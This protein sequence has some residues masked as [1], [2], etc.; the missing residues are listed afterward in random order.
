[1]LKVETPKN[2]RAPGTGEPQGLRAWGRKGG[3][4]HI[5][6]LTFSELKFKHNLVHQLSVHISG[7]FFPPISLVYSFICLFI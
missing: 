1:M 3:S 7:C 6:I 5:A 2:P 4:N